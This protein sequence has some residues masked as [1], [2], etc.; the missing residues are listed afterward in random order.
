MVGL[1]ID[2]FQVDNFTQNL[3][4]LHKPMKLTIEHKNNNSLAMLGTL[5]TQKQNGSLSLQRVQKKHTHGPVS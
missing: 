3:K 4:T 1:I 5:I 2:R